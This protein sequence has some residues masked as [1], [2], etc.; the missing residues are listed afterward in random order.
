[1][2]EGNLS[3]VKALS[4]ING[5]SVKIFG[6]RS[7]RPR[8]ACFRRRATCRQSSYRRG[9]QRCLPKLK[10]TDSWCLAH[11]AAISAAA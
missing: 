8:R 5:D 3:T 10:D 9:R 6:K 1:V 11:T 4:F 7:H 2:L